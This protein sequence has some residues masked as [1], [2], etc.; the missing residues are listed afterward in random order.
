MARDL[1]GR[2]KKGPRPEIYGEK[3]PAWKGGIGVYH[4]GYKR[5]YINGQRFALHRYV[6][7]QH[8]GRKLLES[9]HVHHIDGDKSNNDISNLQVMDIKEHSKLHFPRITWFDYVCSNCGKS[10]Q[11]Y[12]CK[13][14][15]NSPACSRSCSAY[16]RW[17]KRKT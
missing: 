8:L 12:S 6:M 13:V 10:F 11:G 17:K 15:P 7:E 5:I 9:E 3:N 1:K 2:F 4:S 14:N 16:L